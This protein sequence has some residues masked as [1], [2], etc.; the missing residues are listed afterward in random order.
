MIE[1]KRSTSD[2]ARHAEQLIGAWF[3]SIRAAPEQGMTEEAVGTQ[4]SAMELFGRNLRAGV[5]RTLGGL[6]IEY[7][8]FAAGVLLALLLFATRIPFGF[9]DRTFGWRLR[10]RVVDLLA[11]A[12]PG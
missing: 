4:Q 10:E 12:S 6:V 1:R 3:E 7:L 2:D 11:R 8:T 5:V 9:V